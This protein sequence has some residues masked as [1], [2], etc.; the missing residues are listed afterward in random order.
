MPTPGLLLAFLAELA[1]LACAAH[2]L[3]NKR[4]TSSSAVAWIIFCV[5]LPG[6]GAFFY[7]TIGLDSLRRRRTLRLRMARARYRQL[8]AGRPSRR[9]AGRRP[10]E[11]EALAGDMVTEGNALDF[12]REGE[13]FYPALLEAIAG[14]QEAIGL[15]F[16]IFDD[17]AMGMRIRDALVA[18]AEAGVVVRVLFDAV[19]CASVGRAFWDPLRAAGGRVA[20]FLPLNLLRWRWRINLRNHRKIAI[21]DSR[22]GFSGSINVSDRHLVEQGGKSSDL[23]FRVR[24]P[25]LLALLETFASD[26]YYAT[27][28]DLRP[29][30][31]APSV[32]R[33][34]GV[35]L[36]AV[37]SGPDQDQRRFHSL[38]LHAIHNA[39]R[40]A[41]FVTPYF[42]PDPSM[43]DAVT[44]AARR[45]VEVRILVPEFPDLRLAGW[46]AR[47]HLQTVLEGGVQVFLAPPPMIHVKAALFD[48]EVALLGSSNL[49]CRS[50]FLNFELDFVLRGPEIIAEFSEYLDRRF[51]SARRLRLLE[52][53]RRGLGPRLL[54][55]LASLMSPIL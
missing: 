42:V 17:D 9:G 54:H 14:A 3:L 21:I 1:G 41:S 52:D 37:S 12:L 5:V 45:G 13:E 23:G 44:D 30:F 15:Q 49:D 36:L 25:I 4:R 10:K 34:D 35:S 20:P 39:H 6:L 50:F 28:E 32:E 11:E 24:G 8:G 26:W 7:V 18:R 33:A 47:D 38:L 43:L 40:T 16:Y 19:G 27:G 51:R 53:A 31:P 48:G 55:R 46:A 2:A 22:I 29:I